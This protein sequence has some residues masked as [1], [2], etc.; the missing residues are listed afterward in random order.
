VDNPF[1]PGDCASFVVRGTPAPKGSKAYKGRRRNGSAIL[2]ESA[3]EALGPW[4]ERVERAARE[5][6][7]A[8]AGPVRV[9]LTFW[10]RRPARPRYPVPGVK[11]DSDKLARAV[12]DALT[13]AGTIEDDA[14]VVSLRVDKVYA[15]TPA[16]AGCSVTVERLGIFP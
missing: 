14:R 12:L 5:D 10:L 11:P 2:V 4:A 15:P 16:E 1:R 7:R 8:L 3:A 6:G 13:A 9:S